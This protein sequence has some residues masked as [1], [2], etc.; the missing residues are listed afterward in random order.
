MVLAK[1]QASRKNDS[2]PMVACQP[3]K[4]TSEYRTD[5]HLI[6]EMVLNLHPRP[7]NA[8][9]QAEPQGRETRARGQHEPREGKREGGMATREARWATARARQPDGKLQTLNQQEGHGADVERPPGRAVLALPDREENQ[10]AQTEH[11]VNPI[12]RAAEETSDLAAQWIGHS[13][14]SIGPQ[15][16]Q[17]QQA[18]AE[19]GKPVS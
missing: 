15:A 7:T 6:G 2:S 16:C 14:V 19:Q 4:S 10:Q 5:Q 17:S 8:D 1:S 18:P 3:A 11:E 9:R 13:G 12:D